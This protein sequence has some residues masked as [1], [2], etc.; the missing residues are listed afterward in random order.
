MT[1]LVYRKSRAPEPNIKEDDSAA[2]K[3]S[4][5]F[6]LTDQYIALLILVFN[7]AGLL[8]VRS[9]TSSARARA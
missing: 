1:S 5:S 4:E 2:S 8:D 6:R 7:K 3:P 9:P